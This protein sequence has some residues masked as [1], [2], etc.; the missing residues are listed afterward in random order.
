MGRIGRTLGLVLAVLGLQL[1]FV[2]SYV[3]AF[4]DPA[5]HEIP[6]QVVAPAAVVDRLAA[7]LDGTLTVTGADESSA[8]A[9]LAADETAGVLIVD[10]TGTRDTLLVASAAGTSEAS[11]VEAVVGRAEAGQGR[12][13]TVTDLVAPQDGDARGLSGFYLVTG[14]IVGGY[15]LAALLGLTDAA[16]PDLRTTARRLGV[17]LGFAVLG[18]LGGALIAGPVLGALTG[19]VLALWG[20][21]TL[22][23]FAAAAVTVALSAL[24]GVVGIGVTILLFVILG[25]PSAGGAYQAGVLPA[26]WSEIGSRLPNGA[27]VDAL[28]RIVY[29]DAAGTTGPLLVAGAWAVGG[30]AVALLTAWARARREVPQGRHEVGHVRELEPVG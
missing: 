30:V 18:G 4:H 25:N 11:A 7:G 12:T 9:A 10:P 2:L 23:T 5:P 19:H 27:G 17:A 1:G 3:G 6:V 26:F 14:W 8:R 16:R 22:L 13:L 20:L 24:L 28:R 15:L 21:G 29:F